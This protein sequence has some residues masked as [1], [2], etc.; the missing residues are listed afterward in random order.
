MPESHVPASLFAPRAIAIAGASSNVDSPGHDY[1]RAIIDAGFTGAIYPINPRATEIAG[2]PATRGSRL[3][4]ETVAERDS[5]AVARYRAAGLVLLG[6]TNTPELGRN[7]STESQL[8]GPTHNPWRSGYS[9]GGSSGGSAA[10][11]AA[12]L[13][14]AA[15]GNDGGGHQ[16]CL[17]YTS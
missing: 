7:A 16:T 15:H 11:V 9:S 13:V 4:A 5:E 17:L 2:L 8:H 12:G 6:T 3:W 10:A 14:P 1:V